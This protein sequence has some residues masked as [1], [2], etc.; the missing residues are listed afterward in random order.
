M[1]RTGRGLAFLLTAAFALLTIHAAYPEAT[2]AS[3][4]EATPAFQEFRNGQVKKFN[5]LAASLQA[6]GLSQ[7][8]FMK[9]I[10]EYAQTKLLKEFLDYRKTEEGKKAEEDVDRESLVVAIHLADDEKVVEQV[11][12]FERDAQKALELKLF[13][14]EQYA[15][16]QNKDRAKAL[17][18]AV[19]KES[20]T[21]FPD[22]HQQAKMA[23]FRVAPEGQVFPE[24]PEWA[25]DTD[26]K[27]LRVAEYKGKIL[28]VDFWASWCGPC[29]GEAPNLVN[30]YVKYHGKGFEVIGI[31]FDQSEKEFKQFMEDMKMTWREY[32]D[33]LGWDNKVGKVYGIG[34]IP[35][36][37]LL[38]KEGK[39]I[40][41]N[42]R[43]PRL[44]E[45]LKKYLGGEE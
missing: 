8:D 22:I 14:A 7:D 6:K 12:Q 21:K 3:E 20:E 41:D 39:V 45:I 16:T 1:A 19:L 30:A 33:G 43:G 40:T 44:E 26:G 38:D 17:V 25:K 10:Q 11:L 2:G 34:A 27:P 28:L 9:Q 18:N 4:K 15:G 36:M 24:F 13:A 31:S 29:R 35:A 37:Y 32:F 5:E 23:L 42:A